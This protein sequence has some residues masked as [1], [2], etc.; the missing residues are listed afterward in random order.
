MQY[1]QFGSGGNFIVIVHAHYF[2]STSPLYH[3]LSEFYRLIFIRR[4]IE[5]VA[6]IKKTVVGYKAGCFY[7]CV[8]AVI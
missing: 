7:D 4:G 8:T 3:N 1:I 5:T 6:E 2:G